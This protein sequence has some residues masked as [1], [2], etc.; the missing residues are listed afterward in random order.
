[1]MTSGKT[2]KFLL[3]A[4]ACVVAMTGM[5]QSQKISAS[6]DLQIRQTTASL[7]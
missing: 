7:L 4:Y 5:A 2:K 6:L 1:M 3:I